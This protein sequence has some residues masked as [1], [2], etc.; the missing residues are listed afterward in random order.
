MYVD[1]CECEW[2]YVIGLHTE[3]NIAWR[4]GWG[5]NIIIESRVFVLI[6]SYPSL[7]VQMNSL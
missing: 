1:G 7:Q 6:H 3:G 5:T 2:I 4:F